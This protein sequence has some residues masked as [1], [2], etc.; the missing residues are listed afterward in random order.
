[1]LDKWLVYVLTWV[2]YCLY[3]HTHNITVEAVHQGEYFLGQKNQ[4]NSLAL[5][6]RSKT[7]IR[8]VE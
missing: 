7:L 1:M 6:E 3:M 2:L 4:N 5:L 8:V